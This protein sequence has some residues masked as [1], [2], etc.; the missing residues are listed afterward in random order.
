LDTDKLG[1]TLKA[2]RTKP[3][4]M[5]CRGLRLAW[6]RSFLKWDAL[7][8]VKVDTNQYKCEKCCGVFKLREVQVDHKTPCVPVEGWDSVQNFAYRL[9]CPSD[10]LQVLCQDKCHLKKS[11]KENKQRRKEKGGTN[12]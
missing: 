1:P 6:D 4:L 12:A 5:A 9:F 10:Q 3:E 11:N 2:K 8:R 7:R